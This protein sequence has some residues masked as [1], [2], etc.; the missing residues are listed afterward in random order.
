MDEEELILLLQKKPTKGYSKLIQQYTPLVYS[1]VKSQI[2]SYPKEDV[3]ECVSDIF[4][5]FYVNRE[6]IDLSKG[7]L[8]GFLAFVAK[9][10]AIDLI[11]KK[12]SQKEILQKQSCSFEECEAL[13]ITKE[14]VESNLVEKENRTELL[15]AIHRLG[16]PD[17]EIMIRKYFYGQSSKEIAEYLQL[18]PN[19][20][21]KKVGRNLG[22]LRK[23]LGGEQYE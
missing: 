23:Y 15:D 19:T 18:K 14:N 3:E 12:E 16:Q 17:S 5:E 11:R 1:V 6:K 22:K 2:S 10:R 21:D 20:I 4:Y 8:K 13:L 9:R 7:S